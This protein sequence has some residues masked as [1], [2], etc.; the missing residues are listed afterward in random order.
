MNAS[1][2]KLSR[3]EVLLSAGA[4]TIGFYLPKA[5]AA[6]APALTHAIFKPNAFIQIAADNSV[7]VLCKHIEFGQGPMTG[8][9]TVV[10]EE[11]DAD[12]SQMR[13]MHAPSDPA[14]YKNLAFGLQGTGGSTSLGN[15]Y[16]Q[17]REAGAAA[18]QLLISAA[19][20][21]W[22]VPANEIT[23][24][25]GVIRHLSSK[26]QGSFGEFA[27][28]AAQLPVPDKITLKDSK[29]FKYIGKE[30]TTLRRLD[31][32]DKSTGKTLFGIDIREPKLLTVIIAR[33]PRFGAMMQKFDA[34][35][36]GAIPGVVAVK[37]VP[38]GVAIYATGMWAAL[39]ARQALQVSWDET[40]AEQRGSEQ[41][42]SEYRKLAATPGQIAGKSGDA[43]AELQQTGK[44]TEK[45]IDAEF[46]FPFLAHAPMEPL[47]GYLNWNDQNA[48]ARFG[49][50]LQTG[51]HNAIAKI[52]GL[53]V[54]QV[55][56]ETLMAGGSFGR[57]AQPDM[58][59]AAEL[60]HVAK[61]LGPGQPVKLVWTREDDIRGGYYRPFY[62]HRLRATLK[63]KTIHAW[64]NTI[65]GQSIV[66][67]S[68]FAGLIQN[69]IDST[70]VE[71]A[72]VLPYDIAHFQCDLHTTS[73]GIPPLWWRSVGH[74]HTAYVVECVIDELLE[75]AGQDPI[76]GRLGLMSKAPRAAGVLRAVA[77]AANW[78][79]SASVKG[80][81]RGV[82]VAESFGS[83]VAQIAEV[84]LN[85]DGLPQVHQ[86]WCAV[87]CGVAVNPDVIRA[88]MEGG[89]GYALGH[90]L[91]SEIT[92]DKG[93]VQQ[94]N[95]DS[96]R[97]LRI[98]EMPQIHVTIVNSD[99][100]PSG[101]GE[102]G[103]PPLAPAV[104]NAMA[105]LGR[106]RPRQLPF[107]SGKPASA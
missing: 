75:Q 47:S 87:D 6:R 78:D 98:N 21:Q 88:Q 31:S 74:T 55:S 48:V 71:G 103:V 69:G 3:R 92:L 83:F 18:R 70:S 101:V 13:A 66:A 35:A 49:S 94:S 81:A 73:L 57:R 16:Q 89:I 2:G 29:N 85:S 7:T 42:L 79:S 65:V 80:R 76:Q 43:L 95:F 14:L 54:E 68:P 59:F 107:S 12:W 105:K 17:L 102:P 34:A 27:A 15:S 62:I 20:Q 9:A 58:H 50:Q 26:R 46:V 84:S 100:A 4:L 51:D 56:I 8:L 1:V 11:M 104:A 96:Y 93:V 33:P 28:Q 61:A 39:K 72:R 38:S 30:Q 90:A 5:A 64:H 106:A 77:K 86:V 37:A 99:A 25:N 40:S 60:A 23:V 22:Q 63:E 82:A 44:N 24:E 67:G 10:A 97:S 45:V 53:P 41:I 52:L 19:A 36:A 32:A 91:Y